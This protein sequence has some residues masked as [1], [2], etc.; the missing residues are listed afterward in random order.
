MSEHTE[1]D[2]AAILNPDSN[3]E[4]VHWMARR[5][6]Q[7]GPAGVSAAAAG[8]FALGVAATV[9]ALMLLHWLDPKPLVRRRARSGA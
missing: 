3:G 6:L 7:V 1:D 4:L 8:A 9:T 5:P 2:S